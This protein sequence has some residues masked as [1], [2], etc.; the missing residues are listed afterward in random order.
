MDNAVEITN[1][2]VVGVDGN[3]VARN[4]DWNID[5]GLNY[6][7]ELSSGLQGLRGKGN[8]GKGEGK[9]RYPINLE[10]GA[11]RCRPYVSCE[12]LDKSASLYLATFR[13]QWY[14]SMLIGGEKSIRG[15]S[16]KLRSKRRYNV[17]ENS[18]RDALVDHGCVH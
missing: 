6:L 8:A 14:A 11:W 16:T 10:Q 17:R 7:S 1:K 2:I 18:G 5:L 13:F 12:D 4:L 9:D 15:G 3:W